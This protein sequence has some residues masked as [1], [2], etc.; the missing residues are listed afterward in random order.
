MKRLLCM[1]LALVMTFALFG[2]AS[3][4]PA[5]EKTEDKPQSSTPTE[6]KEEKEPAA[7]SGSVSEQGTQATT[8]TEETQ[9]FTIPEDLPRKK[10]AALGAYS[11]NE[12]YLQ[13]RKNLESLAK[14]FNVEFQFV[15]V[16]GSEDLASTVESLCTSGIDGII[17][18]MG[19]ESIVQIAAE[20]NV[21]YMVYCSVF[22]DEL[23]QAMAGYDNFCGVVAE[24]DIVAAQHGAEAMYNAG[25]RSVGVVGLTRGMSDMMDNR[26]DYFIKRFEELGGTVIATDYTMMKFADSISTFAAAYPDMDGIWCAILNESIFQAVTTEGLVG[27]VKLGGFDLSDSS[28]DFYDNETLVFSCTGQQATIVASFAAL[29]NYMYDGT[30]LIE[31]RSVIVPR[32]F[33]EIGNANEYADYD[34][35]VRFSTCYSPEEIGYMIKAFNPDYTFEDYK[36]MNE[37][38]SIQDVMNRAQ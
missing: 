5:T 23:M 18:Q 32:S 24:D 31:D 11:G 6:T 19:S 26:A 13:W 4:A 9:D 3:S 22:S 16:T 2:C 12:L 10:V 30:Y 27:Q 8:G 28:P 15:E 36:T 20:H 7:N 1:L 14:P 33:I 17:T 25:C 21:P 29:Y 35:Y 37:V 38:F 34:Q